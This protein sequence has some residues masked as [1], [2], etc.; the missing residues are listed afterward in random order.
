MTEQRSAPSK[1]LQHLHEGIAE[2]RAR[3]AQ[4]M[5]QTPAEQRRHELGPADEA[6]VHEHLNMLDH[7]LHR[8]EA[9]ELGVCEVCHESVDRVLL[10]VDFDARVCL[11]HLSELEARSLERELEL[12]QSVQKSLLPQELPSVDGLEIAAYSRPAEI[13]T[14][15]YFDFYRFQDGRIG[16]AIADAAGHG[17][18]AG[19]QIAGL[20][21]LMRAL[22]SVSSS[23][24]EVMQRIHGLYRHNFRFT[25]L[26]SLFLMAIDPA[27]GNLSYVNAG[28]NP[29]LLSQPGSSR[30]EALMPTGP[31]L[32]L[33]EQ[34]EYLE[35]SARLDP[36]RAL[37]LYTDGL[38]EAF[39]AAGDQFG[40]ERLERLVVQADG[41]SAQNLLRSLRDDLHAFLGEAPASDDVTLVT[42]R[43]VG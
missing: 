9:G 5:E 32:G 30:T 6:S 27:D 11:D 1:R 10:E 34:A 4:W 19:L 36:G 8:S 21:S 14:G 28:H 40:Q 39:N 25:T 15:D 41:R 20:Q 17:V 29:P 12:A 16:A 3:L 22:T 13:V 26:V 31:A 18:S 2:K 35:R 42:L 24:A 43:R 33:T 37:T 23:P 38:P 7:A